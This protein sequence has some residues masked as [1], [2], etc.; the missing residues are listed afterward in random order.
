MKRKSIE[1]KKCIVYHSKDTAS[2]LNND[3]YILN[4][5]VHLE[6]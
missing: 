5:S 3:R 2:M 1:C 6:K 4:N